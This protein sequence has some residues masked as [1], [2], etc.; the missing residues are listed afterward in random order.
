MLAM[1]PRAAELY[2]RQIAQGLD[3]NPR[4]SMRARLFLREALNGR[5]DLQP[6]KD[7]SLWASGA[8][9]PAAL[10]QVVGNC[11]SGG[12]LS[13]ALRSSRPILVTQALRRLLMRNC[14]ATCLW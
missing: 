9:Q 14:G 1:L 6:G 5:I 4:E 13:L 10:L 11:G 2:R 7:S 8:L 3:G 12:A